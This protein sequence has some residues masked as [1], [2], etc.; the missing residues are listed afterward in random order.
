MTVLEARGVVKEFRGGDG[1]TLR[2]LDG[3][4]V[5]LMRGEMLAIVGASGTGNGTVTFRV[6]KNE[7]KP[8]KGTLT[9]AGKT[10]TVDQNDQRGK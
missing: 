3:V 1:S 5:S 2:I 6:D 4:A 7:G 9:V 10:F 8:R